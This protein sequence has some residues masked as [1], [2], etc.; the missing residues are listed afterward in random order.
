MVF[1]SSRDSPQ[2]CTTVVANLGYCIF[3]LACWQKNVYSRIRQN[4]KVVVSPGPPLP[5]PWNPSQIDKTRIL[6]EITLSDY[7]LMT[8]FGR[9]AYEQMLP[10]IWHVSSRWDF[11]FSE[12]KPKWISKDIVAMG[13]GGLFYP[14]EGP[15]PCCFMR[16][17]ITKRSLIH[18]ISQIASESTG[19]TPGWCQ[20]LPRPKRIRVHRGHIHSTDKSSN[21]EQCKGKIKGTFALQNL[22]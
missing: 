9:S 14:R 7:W 13:V 8:L 1:T 16:Q 15:F 11:K 17:F 19:K 22:L 6:R 3:Y 10:H 5:S 12:V 20:L 2:S 4:R 18:Y 21:K